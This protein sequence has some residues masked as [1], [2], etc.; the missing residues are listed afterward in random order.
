MN[1]IAADHLGKRDSKFRRAHGAR[2]RQQHFASRFNMGFEMTC[3]LNRFTSIEVTKMSFQKFRNWPPIAGI[4]F[5]QFGGWFDVQC[6]WFEGATNAVMEFSSRSYRFSVLVAGDF[7]QH[8]DKRH[9]AFAK[10]VHENGQKARQICE[11]RSL[12]TLALALPS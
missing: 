10:Q 5:L 8:V 1:F 6:H 7:R 4:R 3:R 9:H 2:H 11:S 12:S